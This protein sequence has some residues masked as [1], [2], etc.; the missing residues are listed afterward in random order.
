MLVQKKESIVAAAGAADG[1][2]Y[3]IASIWHAATSNQIFRRLT[4][5]PGYWPAGRRKNPF[6]TAK[7]S[8]MR[9]ESQ[10]NTTRWHTLDAVAV[11]TQLQANAKFGDH[12]LWPEPDQNLT[13]MP[14]RIGLNG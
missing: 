1:N 11:L 2:Q 7:D 9:D 5:D 3:S 14:R 8:P 6:D 4:P 10:T 13:R 12:R